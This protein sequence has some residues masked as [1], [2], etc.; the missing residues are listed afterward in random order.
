MDHRLR[1]R[2]L[3]VERSLSLGDFTLAS[4]ARSTYYIDARLTTMSSEGQFLLG[5]LGLEGVRRTF[6]Q[7]A[8][9]GGLTLGADPIAYAIAHRSWIEG[10]PLEAFTVRKQP[11]THGSARRV[12][13]G[14]PSGAPVVVVEDT[15]TSGGSSLEAVRALRDHGAE[16]LGVWTVV[17]RE[18]GGRERFEEE[19]LPLVSLFTASELLD[20]AGAPAEPA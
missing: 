3:L 5:L 20:A 6:P 15:L 16:V 10:R 1:L 13:G 11:K 7:A 14:L 9:V 4:G 17:D 18:A 2:S 12:E 19:G 8:W